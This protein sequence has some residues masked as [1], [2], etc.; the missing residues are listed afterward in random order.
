[1]KKI[2]MLLFAFGMFATAFA[3]HADNQNAKRDILGPP[4]NAAPS[5]SH[6]AKNVI[7]GRNNTVY[8][9]TNEHNNRTPQQDVYYGKHGKFKK[10][11]NR[12]DDDDREYKKD[13]GRHLGWQKGKG[14]PHRNGNWKD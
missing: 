1:M 9:S 14:N 13:N 6:N 8:H 10:H 4:K 5:T 7:L 3:Q 12:W 2:M 11:G